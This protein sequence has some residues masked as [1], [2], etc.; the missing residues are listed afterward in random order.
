[1]AACPVAFIMPALPLPA[2]RQHLSMPQARSRQ[3]CYVCGRLQLPGTRYVE[4]S[5]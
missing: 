4:I 1:M 2:K 5:A 3:R